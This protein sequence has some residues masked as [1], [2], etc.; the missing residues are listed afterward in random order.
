MAATLEI[1]RGGAWQAAAILTPT[2][3][4]AGLEGASRFEYRVEY[5]AD[6]AGAETSAAAGLSCRYPADFQQY[7]LDHWPPFVLDLLP[8][9]YG[10][11]QWLEQLEL[12]DGPTADWPLLLHGTAYPPGNIRVAEAV[13]AK[14]TNT[15]VPTAS[16]DV[17]AM[18]D[19]PGFARADVIARNEA[20]VEYAFQHGIYAAG[21]SDVQGVA[22]KLLLARDHHGI[23]H[24]E[25]RLA[26]PAVESH[27]LVK[28]PR[29]ARADDRK[30]LRNEAAYMRVAD[31]LGLEVHAELEWEE[32]NLFVPRFDRCVRD[33]D[34][35]RYGMESLYSAAGVAEYG[36]R[37]SHEVL[38]DAIEAYCTDPDANLLEYLKRDVVN[39]VMGNKD[40][41]GRNTALLRHETGTV[42][43]TPLFDFAPMYLDPEGIARVCRWSGDAETAGDPDWG[44]VIELFPGREA[45]LTHALRDFGV[46]L[47]QLPD[48]MRD[49]GVDDDIIEQRSRSIDAHTRQLLAL[50]E[51]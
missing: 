39:V 30:V 45:A 28:R 4:R 2:D 20:F 31:R 18:K 43:L 48:I 10:R 35:E 33:G 41:H 29:G 19:H 51:T 25:G 22:P 24:A 7:R 11:Q 44:K 23:W 32:D 5:A 42:K 34:V 26:D 12:R 46:Q 3:E 14:D 38:C 16:G 40:N 6:F 37:I 13:A 21:A 27:W 1:Y 47:Q 17:V 36:A 9:G 8:S 50:R 15:L 49:C